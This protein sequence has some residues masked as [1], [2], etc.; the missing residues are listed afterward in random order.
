MNDGFIKPFFIQRLGAFILDSMLVALVVSLIGGFFVD[1]KSVSKIQ[2]NMVE[3]QQKYI[4]K[5]I[6][7][8]AGYCYINFYIFVYNVFYCLSIL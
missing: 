4:N 6:N 1:Q 5:D 2:E 7:T 3:I 8:K